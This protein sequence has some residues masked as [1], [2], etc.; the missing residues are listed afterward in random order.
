[1]SSTGTS[2]KKKR[3]GRAFDIRTLIGALLGVYG[4]ILTVMGLWFTSEREMAK[5]D[6]ENLNLWTGLGLLAAAALFGLWAWLRP[7]AVPVDESAPADP[8]RH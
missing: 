3:V 5:V 1:M 7:L 6:G 8:A 2:P 4:V